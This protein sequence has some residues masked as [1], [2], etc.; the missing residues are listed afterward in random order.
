MTDITLDI[1]TG[2]GRNETSWKN[3]KITWQ[4][5]C[6]KLSQTHYTAETMAEYTDMTKPRQDEVKDIGGFV[7]GILAGGRRNKS[8]VFHRSFLTL[9][10][11]SAPVGTWDLYCM[12]FSEAACIYSTH[13][14]TPEKPRYRLLMPLSRNVD[15]T[16]Y[17]AIGRWVAGQLDIEAFDHTG[18]Q[19]YRLM[20]WPSTSKD[21]VYEYQQQDGP[22]LDADWVLNQY[23]DYRD[24]SVWPVS[25]TVNERIDREIKKQGDPLTKKGILGAFCRAYSITEVLDVYLSDV[26]E[27]ADTRYT[28]IKGTTGKGLVVYDD[29]FAYSHHGTDPVSGRLCNAFDLVRLHKFGLQDEDAAKTTP[30]TKLP[31]YKAMLELARNDARVKAKWGAEEAERAEEIFGEF[32]DYESNGEDGAGVHPQH[33][34]AFVADMQ[35]GPAGELEV[36]P[37]GVSL[38]LKDYKSRVGLGVPSPPVN[39]PI[40]STEEEARNEAWRSLLERD[41]KGDIQSTIDNMLMILRNDRVLRGKIAV[42]AFQGMLTVLGRL[43][44]I[45]PDVL[46]VRPELDVRGRLYEDRDRD[47]LIWYFEYIYNIC[48]DK[49]LKAAISLVASENSYHPVKRYLSGLQW[50]GVKRLGSLLPKYLGATG[51]AYTAAV[52]TKWAV[53]CVARV[54]TPGCKF[55]NVLT[56]TGPEGTYKSTFLYLLGDPW[57]SDDFSFAMIGSNKAAEQLSGKWIIEVPEMTGFKTQQ[58]EGTKAFVRK[59]ADRQR[60]AYK[61][62]VDERPRQCTFGASTNDPEP[63]HGSN[64]NRS[65]WIVEVQAGE[66]YAHIM[67]LPG[68]RDQVWA[69]AVAL[70]KSGEELFLPK[71]LEAEARLIQANFTESD[72][73]TDLI[74]E[75]LDKP[76]TENWEELDLWARKGLLS[77]DTTVGEATVRRDTVTLTEIWTE[78]LGGNAK[79]IRPIDARNIG[80]IMHQFKC[81]KRQTLRRGDRL[82]KGYRRVTNL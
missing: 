3:S 59:R 71:D 50:D 82:L 20:Y 2:K 11:D 69:E 22:L 46:A 67:E 17:E 79:D 45:T 19:P 38:S 18:F 27:Q 76:I 33:S 51:G 14:H 31:S 4:A 40:D 7:G 13:K 29:K 39:L 52:M 74:A 78:C 25:K 58:I 1:A 75:Y 12:L 49:K 65:F 54:F 62:N 47:A 32:V 66:P 15:P 37:S 61:E 68:E 16:E 77:G 35:V 30:V 9:D 55:E 56:F 81:W 41:D 80:A 10:M 63:L 70:F 64:G 42:D 6:A 5:L 72:S 21:G 57:F 36:K 8:S 24:T 73:R 60:G 34:I 23:Y 53:A 28:Y 26:Y 44:G 48:S 43:P